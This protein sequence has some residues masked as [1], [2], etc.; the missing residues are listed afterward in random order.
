MYPRKA[1]QKDNVGEILNPKRPTSG[2]NFNREYRKS[3]KNLATQKKQEQE[4]TTRRST[5]PLSKLK[6]FTAVESR[7]KQQL[8][9]RST[10]SEEGNTNF[11]TKGCAE[12]RREEQTR[13]NREKAKSVREERLNATKPALPVNEPLKQEKKEEV[14]YVERNRLLVSTYKQ[15][16]TNDQNEEYH[17]PGELPEFYSTRKQEREQEREQMLLNSQR[18]ELPPGIRRMTEAERQDTLS[19]LNG[20]IQELEDALKTFPLGELSMRN[21]K[22]KTEIE[23]SLTELNEALTIFE[24]PIVYV[25]MDE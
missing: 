13:A 10:A 19:S 15:S 5:A 12:R 4:Q 8:T 18:E 2:R 24:A 6:Q 25:N 3:L 1:A 7:V 21:Q 20:R 22:K 23:H 16:T 9:A 17:N 11:L 14:N